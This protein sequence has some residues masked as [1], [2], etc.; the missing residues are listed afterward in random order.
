MQLRE[1]EKMEIT[2]LVDNYSDVLLEDKDN[3]KRMKVLPPQAP[4]AEH[5]LACLISVYTGDEKHT[6]LM[7]AGT[8]GT[9]LRHNAELLPISLGVMTGAVQHQIASVEAIVL[10]HGHYDHFAGLFKFLQSTEQQLPVIVHP[11]A[12]VDRRIKVGPDFYVPM[13]ALKASELQEAGAVLDMRAD[14][15]TVANDLILVTGKVERATDFETGSPGLEALVD[16]HWVQDPFEDD[17]GLVINLKDQGLVVIGGCSHSGIIN[18]IKHACN[19]TG[20]DQ[21]HA[22][23]GGFH[24]AGPSASKIEP[25]IAAMKTIAPAVIVPLHCTGWEAAN[26]FAAAMPDQFILNSVG[27]TYQFG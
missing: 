3:A 6:I 19:I 10:S 22:V 8:S 7:D 24:L 26:Q 16:D 21:V 27:T 18:I 1:T 4:L 20:I 13:P 11:G 5:G 2:V 17:Q 25:T 23:L 14:A 9:C 15:S 12:F